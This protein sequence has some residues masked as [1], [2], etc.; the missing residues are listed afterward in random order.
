[1]SATDVIVIGGGIIGCACTYELSSAGARVVLLERGSIGG[2][3]S[4]EA[5]GMVWPSSALGRPD[6]WFDLFLSASR[7]YA[8]LVER[9]REETGYDPEYARP[10]MLRVALEEGER[11]SLRHAVEWMP[12]AGQ[13]AEWLEPEDAYRLEPQLSRDIAGG[14]WLPDAANVHSGRM[15]MAL[16]RAA[17]MRGAEIRR[18]TPVLGL[19]LVGDRVTGVRLSDG[20]LPADWVILAAGAWSGQV[21]RML[22]NPLPVTPVKGQVVVAEAPF[23]WP[24]HMLSATGISILARAEGRVALSSTVEPAGF[25]VRPTLD[26]VVRLA[27]AAARL[28][29]PVATLSLSHVWAGLRPDAP[30]HVLLIGPVDGVGGLIAATGHYRSGILLGPMTGRLVAAMVC[31]PE[32]WARRP[33]AALLK[34]VGALGASR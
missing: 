8:P 12:P 11:A 10:G 17:A 21:S 7:D 2:E 34:A 14:L 6:A 5:T 15:T 30:D 22:P 24:R 16:A 25:D 13:A 31:S 3:C 33:E 32:G 9:L 20:S 28:L 19:E 27:G 29:P 23:G 26:A 18:S 1:V 4:A